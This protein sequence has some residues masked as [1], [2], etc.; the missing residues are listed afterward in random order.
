MLRGKHLV[1]RERTDEVH[2]ASEEAKICLD[3]PL[4]ECNHPHLC[5]RLKTEKKKLLEVQRNDKQRK[6]SKP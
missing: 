6:T 4:A 1:Y 5:K 3:C 2:T